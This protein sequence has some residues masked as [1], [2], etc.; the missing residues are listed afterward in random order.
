M[1][2]N[3]FNG[4]GDVMVYDEEAPGRR[5]GLGRRDLADLHNPVR[6]RDKLNL[7]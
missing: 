7:V 5:T 2:G 3:L 4:V 6:S 1:A